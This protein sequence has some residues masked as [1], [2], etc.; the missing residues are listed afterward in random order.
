LDIGGTK[1]AVILGR[2]D[3][4][5]A[6]FEILYREAIDTDVSV[7]PEVM[8]DRLDTL[9]APLFKEHPIAAIGVS[10]GGPLDSR[11]G[12]ILSPPNLPGWDEVYIVERLT[13]KHGVPA[14]LQND[15]N[16]CGYAEWKFGAGKGTEN[17]I[18]CTMGTGFGAG[19]ILNGQL[20]AGTNDNAGEIGHVRL[21]DMGPAGY[22][23]LGTV[24]GYC[25]G[26]GIAQVGRL[27]AHA[28]IQRGTPLSFCKTVGELDQITAKSLSLAAQNGDET[29]LL[30]WQEVG[31]YLGRAMA[32][33]IDVLNPERIV[34]GSIYARSGQLLRKSME[35][36]IRSEAL[37][38]SAKV[39]EIVPAE[40]GEKIGDIA[41]L[42]VAIL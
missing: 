27:F 20:Y 37:I 31:K 40:L 18:F 28:A 13:Q 39:C 32:I 4:K 42:S 2:L 19:L 23:K 38:H 29:A 41:A 33:L 14:H 5:D 12:V 30:V 3:S 22:G 25:S 16:A 24:E 36:T 26:G 6:S 1:C 10:C 17:M 34:I 7:K 35:E 8:L 9:L 11:R 21:T 15:A